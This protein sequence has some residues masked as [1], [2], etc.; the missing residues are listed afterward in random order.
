MENASSRCRGVDHRAYPTKAHVVALSF[1]EELICERPLA[2]E[3]HQSCGYG[4]AAAS[5]AQG[6]QARVA[7]LSDGR[8]GPTQMR[9]G[10]PWRVGQ[11][12]SSEYL[13]LFLLNL[14]T[15]VHE[16]HL[17]RDDVRQALAKASQGFRNHC[18]NPRKLGPIRRSCFSVTN[19]QVLAYSSMPKG[20]RIY[21]GVSG[22]RAS[23]WTI[24]RMAGA[25]RC[26]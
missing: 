18:R 25:I 22:H 9:L 8:D 20:L 19:L 12:Y 21:K 24:A 3:D 6:V 5:C 14:I 4:L 11:A 23:V 17:C 7:H 2:E 13:C 26:E 10:Q 16:G 1:V 15:G